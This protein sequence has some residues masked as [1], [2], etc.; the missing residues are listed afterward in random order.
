M[1][2]MTVT[3]GRLLSRAIQH[4]AKVLH[5]AAAAAH[6]MGSAGTLPEPFA[7]FLLRIDN[8]LDALSGIKC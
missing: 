4:V 1:P 8:D 5:S 6:W 2:T 7:A 3:E